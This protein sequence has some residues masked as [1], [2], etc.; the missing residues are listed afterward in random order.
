MSL[1][2]FLFRGHKSGVK[3]FLGMRLRNEPNRRFYH[4]CPSPW[5][6]HYKTDGNNK[7]LFLSSG[8]RTPE[9]FF[10]GQEIERRAISP[11]FQHV[12]IRQLTMIGIVWPST[13]KQLETYGNALRSVI[14]SKLHPRCSDRRS[15]SPDK[16]P[17]D[18][19][20][21][22][23]APEIQIIVLRLPSYSVLMMVFRDKFTTERVLTL[24]GLVQEYAAHVISIASD[25]C[26]SYPR[27]KSVIL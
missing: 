21:L 13:S 3:A 9:T 11:H 2:T 1:P 27:E 23:D 12:G 4:T 6:Y 22:E 16:G 18:S 17:S 14:I 19:L 26:L 10:Y 5:Y 24:G 15:I 25:D 8:T 20:R 7:G